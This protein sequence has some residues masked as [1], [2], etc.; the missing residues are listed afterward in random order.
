MPKK[1]K[2]L[3]T[4]VSFKQSLIVLV[5]M[6]IVSTFGVVFFSHS[7]VN[8]MKNEI[9]RGMFSA[10]A[11]Y[12]ETITMRN[13]ETDGSQL[14]DLL[15]ADTGMD[16][17]Y[18]EGAERAATSILNADGQ[19]PLG[20]KAAPEVISNV[21]VSGNVYSSTNTDV[22][23]TPYYVVYMPVQKGGNVSGMA[24]VGLPRT[25]VARYVLSQTRIMM[26]V[27]VSFIIFI[28][29]LM[30]FTTS[31]LISAV[32]ESSEAI[33]KIAA[34]EMD[35]KLSTELLS[36]RDE[37]G[38]MARTISRT[39]SKLREVIGHNLTAEEKMLVDELDTAIEEKQLVVYFQPKYHIQGENPVIDSAEA[40]IRW[41][42]PQRGMI[43]PGLFIP[44]FEKTGMIYRLDLFVWQEAARHINAWKKQFGVTVPVS[45][46]VS[47]TDIYSADVIE[48]LKLIVAENEISPADLHLEI[49]ESAYA[50]DFEQLISI[51]VNLRALGF[52][53]EMDDFGSGYSSLNM[54][55]EL[56]ID[57]IKLDMRFMQGEGHKRNMM[58]SLIFDIAKA[59]AVPSIAEGV[60]T[61]E[62]MEML[63]KMGC[64]IIQGYY[65][66]R[67]LPAAD[68]AA[69]LAS[70][71]DRNA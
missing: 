60:E 71:T 25:S 32:K 63:K 58:L 22:N 5:P 50:R 51:I 36:R 16:F 15:K 44:L 35:V 31:R 46:N 13:G 29:L 67:P 21:L 7:L 33:Q 9:L 30:Y 41:Q 45:V 53:I 56:P 20:T 42:H 8:G 70:Q 14:E 62:Q 61:K 26:I 38:D 6:I 69:L 2:K 43:S 23:G 18:F 59:L 55:A 40:L 48:E 66:S 1:V 64:D 27:S 10:C 65:F 52:K 68:F 28:A 49:T 17:T 34:G 19:K 12:R 11:S 4:S 24:F 39:S 37:F 3:F 47:R 54:L 57:A